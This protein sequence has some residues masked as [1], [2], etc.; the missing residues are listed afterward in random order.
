MNGRMF[1][2][3]DGRS[4]E[5]VLSYCC[6]IQVEVVW[7]VASCSIT[8]GYQRFGGPCCLHLQGEVH[9]QSFYI[10][11]GG[12]RGLWKVGILPQH[13]TSQPRWPR[14]GSSPPRIYQISLALSYSPRISS[15]DHRGKPRKVSQYHQPSGRNS[16]SYLPNTKQ[17]W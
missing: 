11:G 8:V 14:L 10:D 7:V 4:E 6:N 13:Y 9:R 16:K 3:D 5:V 12:N 15:R 2:E 1:V 17:K